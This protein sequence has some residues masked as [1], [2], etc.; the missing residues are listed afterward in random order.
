M[1]QD[2][3]HFISEGVIRGVFSTQAK[4]RVG[5]GATRKNTAQTVYMYVDEQDDGRFSIQALNSSFVPT[6]DSQFITREELLKQYLPEPDV[7][8]KRYL[9]AMKEL[10]E[11]VSR[12]EEHLEN[13]EL[14]SAEYEFKN[15]LRIDEE[16][17]RATFGL[18]LTYLERGEKDKGALVFKRLG[19]IDGAFEESHK[20][21]FNEFGIMLRKQGLLDQAMQHYSRA[22]RLCKSDEHLLYNMS[23]VL[24]EKHRHKAALW[25]LNRA[26]QLNPSFEEGQEL[27]DVLQKKNAKPVAVEDLPFLDPE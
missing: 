4:A 17:I 20:H 25:V 16:N 1:K 26:M 19:N 3:S 21:L 18:G 14:F 22:F 10:E 11:A 7:Y 12:G 15:A 8:M 13:K 2:L 27:L 5:F 6:G 24:Y 9:P 23:R